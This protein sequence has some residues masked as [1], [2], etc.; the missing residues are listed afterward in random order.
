MLIV[1]TLSVSIEL[2]DQA[3]DVIEDR[4]RHQTA[5]MIRGFNCKIH[6]PTSVM[7]K[8]KVKNSQMTFPPVMLTF[9]IPAAPYSIFIPPVVPKSKIKY[10]KKPYDSKQVHFCIRFGSCLGCLSSFPSLIELAILSS[11]GNQYPMLSIQ[12]MVQKEEMVQKEFAVTAVTLNG[13]VT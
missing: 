11:C 7:E 1:M 3:P 13:E 2:T 10:E 8:Y 6:F 9:E 4:I 12:Q 5:L